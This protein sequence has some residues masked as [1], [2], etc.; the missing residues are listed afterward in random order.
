M[1]QDDPVLAPEVAAP[2]PL[3]DGIGNDSCW[4]SVP[5]Q[6]I[7][8]TWIPYGAHVDSGDYSGRYKV[9]W[10]SATNL[11]YFLV[12][13]TDDIFVDGYIPGVPADIYNFDIIEVFI[14][15]DKSGGRHVFDGRDST[16]REWGTNAENAFVYH[17]YADFPEPGQ[18]TTL[19]YSGDLVGTSWADAKPVNN[20]SHLP[21]FALRR[22]GNVAT[23]EFSLIVYNDT[24]EE[25]NK[26]TARAQLA[27]GKE[28]GLVLAYCDNDDP[29]ENP[30]TRDNFFGSVHVP[31]AAYNDL[32]MNADYFGRVKLV[33]KLP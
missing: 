31:A 20:A 3:I 33:S 2:P 7:D 27:V 26:S 32:W 9:A 23:W 6:Q 17:T 19:C 1:A 16:A 4:Q 14:D 21:A 8:Q 29:N 25:D 11:L 12:E 18:V 13:V 28:M 5:W 22:N 15:E 30:K 10:S 24:Y